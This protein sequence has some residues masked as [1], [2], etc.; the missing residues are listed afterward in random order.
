MIICGFPGIGKT[1]F[2]KK[3][4]HIALD[5]ESSNFDKSDPNW[6]VK[7]CDNVIELEK[8]GKYKYIFTASH[9]L[10]VDY[11]R[12]RI[13]IA[14]A[15][16]N[17]IDGDYCQRLYERWYESKDDKDLRAL[18]FAV[19]FS[20]D[21]IRYANKI[22]EGYD[23]FNCNYTKDYAKEHIDKYGRIMPS[24]F[25]DYDKDGNPVVRCILIDDFR[26]LSNI[27]PDEDDS[28]FYTPD[29]TNVDM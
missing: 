9:Q 7:Y 23:A 20:S 22:S 28:T 6:Y 10:V 21:A 14:I 29:L 2:V 5:Y 27:L 25:T 19:C 1:Y 18:K 8:S 12:S 17:F 3:N 16:P 4:P 11:L 26:Y 15:R 24:T 13:S